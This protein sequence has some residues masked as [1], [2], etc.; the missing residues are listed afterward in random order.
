MPIG[1]SPISR[2]APRPS[3]GGTPTVPIAYPRFGM[4]GSLVRGG[5]GVTATGS[6]V[7]RPRGSP[8]AG[9]DRVRPFPVRRLRPT[10]DRSRLCRTARGSGPRLDP[11]LATPHPLEDRQRAWKVAGF[12]TCGQRAALSS[13]ISETFEASDQSPF[14][15]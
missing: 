1:A 15:R 8:C 7:S 14:R 9:T 11:Q 4:N 6:L 5:A 3:P 10:A 12:V 13:L 2:H